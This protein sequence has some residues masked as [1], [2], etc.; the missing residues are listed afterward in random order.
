M[1]KGKKNILV[2]VRDVCGK[3]KSAWALT[4]SVVALLWPVNAVAATTLGEVVCNIGQN[5]KQFAEFFDAL[6]Y[7]A[8][9]FL[10]VKGVMLLKKHAET[11]N[12]SQIVK[13]VAHLVGAGALAALPAVA[14]VLQETLG[15]GTGVSG[16]SGCTPGDVAK[17]V[18]L[19]TMMQSFVKN[20]YSPMFVVLEI[21]CFIMGA[22]LIF[23]GLVKGS[24]VGT[25]PRA[26][27]PHSIIISLVAGAVL[28]SI[29]GMFPTMLKTLFG[30]A[31][32]RDFSH[33]IN[34]SSFA[35]S[36]LDTDKADLTIYA[37]LKFVQI[38]GVIA[39]IR[40]WLIIRNAVEG[41][42]QV[43]VPQGL[44]HIIGGTM[45]I[46]IGEMLYIINTTFGTDL[47]I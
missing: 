18:G 42:G 20:I 31:G 1:S 11:P 7:I 28:L 35:G 13:A 10:G 25:D 21:L 15:V 30:D 14:H 4:F 17:A 9:A 5:I 33:I 46:N 39:F 40:G 41:T 8:G 36:G 29:G 26:A 19:D 24:K 45:A 34:W 27:A 23:R 47:L 2:P 32:V 16:G 37:V 38:I 43:T 6:A 22:Y 44:T 12:E 3:I